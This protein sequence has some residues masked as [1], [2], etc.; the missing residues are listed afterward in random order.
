M[1][2]SQRRQLTPIDILL[3]DLRSGCLA[4]CCRCGS[5]L[6]CLQLHVPCMIQ[7]ARGSDQGCF[8]GNAT[9]P[10]EFLQK[11]QTSIERWQAIAMPLHACFATAAAD[12]PPSW[13][14]DSWTQAYLAVI[15]QQNPAS[16]G[17]LP[18]RPATEDHSHQERQHEIPYLIMRTAAHVLAFCIHESPSFWMA[19]D[20]SS[21]C[22]A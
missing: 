8:E 17:P 1:K 16:G 19:F 18:L 10:Q 2:E 15:E 3:R 20:H 14:Q 21:T 13:S 6:S 4:C 9:F 22:L 5:A 12:L 7:K 11:R